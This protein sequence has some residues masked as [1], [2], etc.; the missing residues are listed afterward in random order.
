MSF[1]D[2]SYSGMVPDLLTVLELGVAIIIAS[3]AVMRPVFDKVFHSIWR[4]ASS[5]QQRPSAEWVH[6]GSY[7]VHPS[8]SEKSQSTHTECLD[9]G[10]Q[11][12][13]HGK[14]LQNHR[15]MAVDYRASDE[16][17]INRGVG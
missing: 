8:S 12:D 13:L 9:A 11:E 15:T 14:R 4:P 6:Y 7:E 10:S 3:S 17:Q 16:E 2:A 5:R 1:A